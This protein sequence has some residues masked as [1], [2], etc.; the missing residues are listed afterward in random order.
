MKYYYF[1]FLILFS[2]SSFSQVVNIEKKRNSDSEKGIQGEFG[3]SASIKENGKQIIQGNNTIKLQYNN[4]KSTVLLFNDLVLMSV[5]NN[6]L[7]NEG[8]Q[9]LRYNHELVPKILIGEAFIQHQYNSI[10][11][12]NRRVLVGGGPRF[13]IV[14]NDTLRIFF[15]PLVM[16]E[17]EELLEGTINRRA[18]MSAYLS[19]SV[20]LFGK[21]MLST[22]AYYQPSLNRLDNYRISNDTSMKLKITKKLS[23]VLTFNMAFDSQPPSEIEKL[24]YTLQ[25]GISYSF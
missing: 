17:H 19:L 12:L 20:N 22:V 18:R 24:F 5:D 8:F 11:K 6:N 13:Q 7:V 14:A 10:K 9:H 15:G 23:Y 3:L 1:I 2:L 16:F 25:N 21:G 4:R